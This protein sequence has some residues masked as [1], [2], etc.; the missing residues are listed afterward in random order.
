MRTSERVLV[1]GGSG[2]I[3][4][5]LC[6]ALR[7][8]GREV[9][10][11]GRTRQ[12]EGPA[13]QYTLGELGAM[14]DDFRTV[15]LLAAAIPYGRPDVLTPELVAANALLPARVAAA[16]RD[17][18]L[19]HA[20]SVSVYGAPLRLPATEEHPFN[21]PGGYGLSKIA[22]EVAAG[23]HPNHVILR[24]SS[25]YGRGMTAPTFLPRLLEQLRRQGRITLYGDGSRRQDYLHVGDAVRMLLAAAEGDA[26]GIFN[27]VR[28]VSVSNAEAAAT[29]IELAGGG[30][31][32]FTGAD[33]SPSWDYSAAKWERCFAALERVD[34]RAGLREM[35][36]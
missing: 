3:G 34:L 9:A 10:L 11:L 36:S 24:F 20:S 23:A 25:V 15:F 21:N 5:R 22:G 1:V 26:V 2:F 27:A 13:E 28:G 6:R 31:I 33:P 32:V 17:A 18:R 14:P 35:L 16:F 30:E 7:E 29:A 12:P 4:R 19:V 8:A